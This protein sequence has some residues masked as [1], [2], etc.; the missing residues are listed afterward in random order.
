MVRDAAGIRSGFDV[1]ALE[2][3]DPLARQGERA[4]LGRREIREID[5]EAGRLAPANL[6]QLPDDAGT[7]RRGRR[8][9]DVLRRSV[10]A[11]LSAIDGMPSIIPVIAPP[12][13]PENTVSMPRL[14]PRLTP[15][16]RRS[17]AV[18]SIR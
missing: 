1:H 8:P 6:Q 11:W 15:H 4:D 14:A 12:T 10:Q 2:Q 9:A 13:V 17:G 5:A 16:S 3:A 18:P 7:E